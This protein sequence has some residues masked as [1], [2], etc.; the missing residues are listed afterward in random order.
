MEFAIH[1]IQWSTLPTLQDTPPLDD[2]DVACLAEVKAVLARHGT[3]KCFAI[4]LAHQHFD[5][6]PGEVL[7]EQPDPDTRTQHVSVGRLDDSDLV[8][9]TTWLFDDAPE[10]RLS[11]ALYCI[12]VTTT[13]S[14]DACVR[15]GRTSDMGET[16][17]KEEE[18]KQRRINEEKAEYERRPPSHDHER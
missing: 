2:T 11:E 14:L 9:P 17:R 15:H 18:I 5:L 13:Q 3:L 1:P 16:H 7:I 4:H 8:R 10:L 12:C 6:A